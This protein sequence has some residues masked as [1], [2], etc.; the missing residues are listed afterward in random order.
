M[1]T[2]SLQLSCFGQVNIGSFQI[3]LKH[4]KFCF[5]IPVMKLVPVNDYKIC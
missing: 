3:L 4:T 2:L 1:Y 5:Y